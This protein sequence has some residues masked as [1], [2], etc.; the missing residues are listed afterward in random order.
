MQKEKVNV[1]ISYLR[2]NVS[3][4]KEGKSEKF[5]MPK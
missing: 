3:T 4:F 1:E 2:D 5:S